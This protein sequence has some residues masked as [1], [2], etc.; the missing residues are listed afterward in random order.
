V[1][2]IINNVPHYHI[3]TY[4]HSCINTHALYTY[5]HI[6]AYIHTYMH[7]KKYLTNYIQYPELDA[8]KI[9]FKEI[10]IDVML[11]F[12]SLVL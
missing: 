11:K 3:H 4:M 5:I 6:Q 10:I 1:H 2:K 8:G 9:H 7:A 12:D